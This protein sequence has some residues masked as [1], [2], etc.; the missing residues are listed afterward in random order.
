MNSPLRPPERFPRDLATLGI[1]TLG[2][3]GKDNPTTVEG[4]IQFLASHMEEHARQ[5]TT[6]RRLI[7][8]AGSQG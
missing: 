6:S 7:S 2:H 4:V 5:I 8:E 1:A 3:R